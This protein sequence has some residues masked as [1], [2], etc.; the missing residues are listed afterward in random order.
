MRRKYSVLVILV[1]LMQIIFADVSFAASTST[2]IKVSGR[3]TYKY[4]N[5]M[6]DSE[7][8][9][10]LKNYTVKLYDQDIGHTHLMGTTKT[11]SNGNFVFEKVHADDGWLA[12]GLDLFFI[13]KAEDE[14]SYVVEDGLFKST[15]EYKLKR[16]DNITK[17]YDFGDVDIGLNGAFHIVNTIHKAADTW[18]NGNPNYGCYPS[19]IK[20]IWRDGKENGGTRCG[21]NTMY[22]QA[23]ASDSD[24]WDAN[25]IWHEYGHFLMREFAESPKGA[26]GDH[27][28]NGIYNKGL[29]YSEGWATYFGQYVDGSPIYRDSYSSGVSTGDIEAPNPNVPNE[30]N[31]YANS[32][33]LWDITDSTNEAL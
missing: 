27:S 12:G 31:E 21:R 7:K 25:V 19:K 13:V 2:T 32:A 22:V 20:V 14:F 17:D 5:S 10:P 15:T 3:L 6:S 1:F 28:G 18:I 33:T 4:K 30:A 16:V 9:A 24:Q 11:D 23:T 26:G 8:S 29:A